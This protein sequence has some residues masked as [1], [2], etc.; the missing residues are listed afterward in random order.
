MARFAGLH[1]E[2]LARRLLRVMHELSF[3]IEILERVQHEA[4]RFPSCRV[5]RV[6]LG[7]G[8]LLC[9]DN[10][11]LAFCLE[12]IAAGTVMDAARIEITE[13]PL[14]LECARCGRAPVATA[15]DP[16]CPACGGTGAIVSGRD[17]V[18]EEIEIHEPDGEA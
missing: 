2:R 6:R 15:L 10:A 9:I 12:A 4:E 7:A 3:A 18:I 13:V 16:R 5:E 11:S 14:E 8:E 17:L 1:W